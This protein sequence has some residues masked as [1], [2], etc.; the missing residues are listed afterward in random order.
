MKVDIKSGLWLGV[1]KLSLENGSDAS[2]LKEGLAWLLHEIASPQ[3]YHA[4]L[5]AWVT[6]SV[7]GELLGAYVNAE[8]R[9]KQFLR[10]RELYDA[11]TTWMYKQDDIGLMERDVAP[12]EELSDLRYNS[13]AFTELCQSPFQPAPSGGGGKGGRKGASTASTCPSLSDSQLLD[14]LDR[15]I[16]M[17]AML[18]QGAV[19]AFT[20]NGDA[21]FTQGK[22][23][24]VVDFS[25]SRNLKRLYYPWDLDGVFRSTTSGIYGIVGK[26]GSVTQTPYQSI[27]LNHAIY[28]SQF[29]VQLSSLIADDGPFGES[30][31]EGL[32]D[33]LAP[34][35]LPALESDP[36]QSADINDFIAMKNWFA[37]RRKSIASQIIKDGPPSPR[38]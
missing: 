1:K 25:A 36:Y 33:R 2:P 16:D 21:L 17:S 22:N 38:P 4:A 14:Q 26:R 8:Q 6:V 30:N 20:D 28:R 24:F 29:N 35:V 9:D 12:T 27:I 19:D 23:F 11:Q 31:L 15:L 37:A 10:N 32:L 3:G 5:A 7:N 34:S 13:P 18:R